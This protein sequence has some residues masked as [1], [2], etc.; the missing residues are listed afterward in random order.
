MQALLGLTRF[1]SPLPAAWLIEQSAALTASE[2]GRFERIKRPLRREQFLVGHSLLRRLLNEVKCAD[3]TIEVDTRGR[4]VLHA[5]VPAYASIAH[6]ANAVAVVVAGVPVGVD[7]E[8]RQS[9]RDPRA[10]AAMLGL[11]TESTNDPTSVL[12]AWVAAEARLKAGPQ[13]RAQTWRSAWDHCQLAVAGTVNP[14]L[15][16]VFGMNT[17][18]YNAA[19]LQWEAA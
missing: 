3:A 18:I 6:S 2:H 5:S 9:L 12:R 1:E 10:A 15:A 19:E 14:P 8:S 13:A 17:R 11:A 7:L 4:L 16:G